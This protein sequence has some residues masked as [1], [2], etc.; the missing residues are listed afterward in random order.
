MGWMGRSKPDSGEI[1]EPKTV[2]DKVDVAS[3]TQL[4]IPLILDFVERQ[5]IWT[6]IG[7][8]TGPVWNNVHNNLC[9]VSLMLQAMLSLRKTSL[10]RLFTLHALA[11]GTLVESTDAADTVFP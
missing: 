1:F 10:L 6:D 2:E 11:R 4:C 8:T 5:V 7:L 3:N 9:G